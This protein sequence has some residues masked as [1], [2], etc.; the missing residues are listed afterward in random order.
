[1]IHYDHIAKT[2]SAYLERHPGEADRLAPI[3]SAL[4]ES[5]DIT[6]R[7]TFPGHLTSSAIVVDPARRAL[8]LRHNVLGKWLGP[9]G[10]LEPGDL[11][12]V[13]AAVREAVEEAGIP[14]D[15]LVLVDDIPADIGVYAIPANAA[16]YEP[17]HLHFDFR[18]LLTVAD[19]TA[20]TLQT[21]EVG[22]FAWLPLAE[23]DPPH[24][25]DRVVQLLG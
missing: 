19:G 20:V 7:G 9:G 18:F 17:A 23:L 13:D 16:R 8:H 12:L 5:D 4:A 10:H 21:A 2:M 25:P 6:F 1:M 11:S 3:G 14:A 15:Q 24:L 22:A